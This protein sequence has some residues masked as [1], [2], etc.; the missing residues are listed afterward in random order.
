MVPDPVDRGRGLSGCYRYP[1][2][3]EPMIV[4]APVDMADS[5]RW[6]EGGGLIWIDLSSVAG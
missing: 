5:P 4:G 6:L 1:R 3:T 2:E